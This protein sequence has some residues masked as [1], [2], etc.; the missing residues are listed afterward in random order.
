MRLVFPFIHIPTSWEHNKVANEFH[1]LPPP[2][3]PAQ[4]LERVNQ[5]L[6]C[7]SLVPVLSFGKRRPASEDLPFESQNPGP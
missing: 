6:K 2:P 5:T 4:N 1:I 3:A 7:E